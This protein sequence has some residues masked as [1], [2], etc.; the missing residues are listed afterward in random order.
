MGRSIGGLLGPSLGRN[1]YE[2]V[3]RY[4]VK[5]YITFLYIKI[6]YDILC[7]LSLTKSKAE[8][9]DLS[10]KNKYVSNS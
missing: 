10:R 8:I 3:Y 5:K 9:K 4:S 7:L 2:W 6:S 1:F